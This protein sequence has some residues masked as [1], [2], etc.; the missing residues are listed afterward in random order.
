MDQKQLL[1]SYEFNQKKTFL[2]KPRKENTKYPNLW[3]L[4][5]ESGFVNFSEVKRLRS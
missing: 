4:S 2:K 5:N 1:R 3:T